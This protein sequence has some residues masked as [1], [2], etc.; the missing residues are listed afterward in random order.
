SAA[1]A[2]SQS[3]GNEWLDSNQEYFKISTAND[4]IHR[5]TYSDLQAAGFPVETD[6]RRIR[7]YHRGR[8][9]AIHIQGQ[10]DARLDPADYVEFYGLKN[11]GT[12]DAELYNTGDQVNPYLNL[13]SDSTAY[14]LTYSLLPENGRRMTYYKE[15][16]VSG[17]SPA[18]YHVQTA[19][20][21]YHEFYNFGVHYPENSTGRTLLTRFDDGEGWQANSIGNGASFTYSVSGLHA[22]ASAGQAPKLIVKMLG[23]SAN[24]HDITIAAGGSAGNTSFKGYR[25]HTYETEINRSDIVNGTLDVTVRVNSTVGD[26]IGVAYIEVQAP[27]QTDMAGQSSMVLNLPE[28]STG[29]TY[30]SVANA[31]DA[32][33]LYDITDKENII[34]IGLSSQGTGFGAVIRDTNAGRKLYATG[35]DYSIPVIQ[36]VEPPVFDL[37]NAHYVIITHNDMRKPGGSY[38]DPVAAYADYRRSAEGGGHNVLIADINDLYNAFSYGERTP[39]AIYRFMR[40]LYENS[41]PEYLFII[42]KSMAWHTF[43]RSGGKR[44]FYRDQPSLYQIKDYV[45]TGGS[46]GSDDIFTAGLGST[47]VE[48]A[49]PTGR[50]NTTSPDQVASYLDKVKEMEAKP[51]AFLWR[52]NLLHLSGGIDQEQAV[53]LDYVKEF[54]NTAEGTYLGGKVTTISKKTNNTVEAINVSDEVNKGVA[55]ITFFGHSAPSVTDIEIGFVSDPVLGYNNKG[56][57]PVFLVNGCE[58]GDIFNVNPTFGED[59]IQAK[60]KG[61]LAFM[62]HSDLGYASLLRLYSDLFY[63]VAFSEERFYDKGIGDIKKEVSSRFLRLAPPIEQSRAQAQQIILQGDPA[64]RIFGADKPDYHLESG[65]AFINSETGE[66]VYADDQSFRLAIPAHNYGRAVDDSLT[67]HVTRTLSDNTTLPVS[68]Y[69]FSPLFYSDTLYLDIDASQ[70]GNFGTNRFEVTIDAENNVEELNEANNTLVYEVFIPRRGTIN[71]LPHPYAIVNSPDVRFISQ[72]GATEISARSFVFEIDTAYT[73]DSPLKISQT[74]EGN[75]LARLDLQLPAVKDSTVFYWRTRFDLTLDGEINEWATSSFSYIKDGPEGWAQLSFRQLSENKSEGLFPMNFQEK[76][77]F[78]PAETF[79]KVVTQGGNHP[80]LS[81]TSIE[82]NINNL[83][84][85]LENRI[86]RTNAYQLIAFDRNTAMPYLPQDEN[87]EY[88]SVCGRLPEVIAA[89]TSDYTINNPY[90]NTY[91]EALNSGDQVVMFSTGS[92]GV[93]FPQSVLNSLASVGVAASQLEGHD[94]REPLIILGQKGAAPGTATVVRASESSTTPASQQEIILET[95]INGNG[96]EATLYSPLIGPALGWNEAVADWQAE[97][98]DEVEVSVYGISATFTEELLYTT[99]STGTIPLDIEAEQYPFIRLEALYRDVADRT[100]AQPQ[101]WLVDYTPAPEGVLLTGVPAINEESV[102]EGERVEVGFKFVNLTDRPFADPFTVKSTLYN[103]STGRTVQQEMAVNAPDAYDTVSFSMVWDTRN[104]P[105]S[106]NLQ[107][108]ANAGRQPEQNYNNNVLNLIGAIDVEGDFYQPVIDLT[109]D[110]RNIQ[111]MDFV[112]PDPYVEIRFFDENK[113]WLKQDTLGTQLLIREDCDTCSFRKISF[114]DPAVN[115]LGASETTPFTITYQ[116][117]MLA[118]GTYRMRIIG[119][120]AAGNAI[121]PEPYEIRFRV[122]SEPSV[123]LMA[124]YPNPFTNEITFPVRITGPQGPD[125]VR[126]D[127]FD[128]TGRQVYSLPVPNASEELS[129]DGT[130][131]LKWGGRDGKGNYLPAGLY[132][133]RFTVLND[134]GELPTGSSETGDNP[135]DKVGKI[136]LVR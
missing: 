7:M 46:P 88:S 59:W 85:I 32:P 11:D 48:A 55:M 19:V 33:R 12:L 97:A 111:D 75:Q 69:T 118:D 128:M 64:L 109:F 4:G 94:L 103:S 67:V 74:V 123:V 23:K 18:P 134:G 15:N 106:N 41:D 43:Y 54:E 56:K 113:A 53:F 87:V 98:N 3:Y 72:S 122:S 20:E 65:Q 115:W 60:D 25:S 51:F 114:S 6:P 99:T 24:Q 45:P 38:S 58:A 16:N 91:F 80:D 61:A 86:C 29:K 76:W 31:P 130:L 8:E 119:S 92:P 5:I 14:F 71:L 136:V 27:R 100:P 39:V 132:I 95:T 62:A 135:A 68:E 83:S 96:D 44:V 129:G 101:M 77:T 105:G 35:S 117:P 133:Y 73:F 90:I 26:F 66:P 82:V 124:P 110:G 1:T 9:V 126:L 89:Y 13:Y 131:T 79:V 78:S 127:I 116:S 52:K 112:R 120:D 108:D 50:I 125:Q 2:Y 49:V 28:N 102:Q 84:Y 30:I 93:D 40:Y 42:G 34:R 104:M 37:S 10:E 121:G 36:Q 47:T 107:T 57:Y 21:S 81:P 70:T 22:I 63:Q 17:M